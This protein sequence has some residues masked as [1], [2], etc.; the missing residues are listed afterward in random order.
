MIK[1][2]ATLINNLDD[3]DIELVIK[4]NTNVLQK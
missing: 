1:K 3:I 4:K 2:I